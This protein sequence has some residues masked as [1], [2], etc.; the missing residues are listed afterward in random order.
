[1]LRKTTEAKIVYTPQTKKMQVSE[2]RSARVR[3]PVRVRRLGVERR[4]SLLL[5]P[6][7]TL[8]LP[9]GHLAT[10]VIIRGCIRSTLS[11]EFFIDLD[12][13]AVLEQ[14]TPITVI[15]IIIWGGGGGGE[16]PHREGGGRKTLEAFFPGKIAAT[17]IATT[18]VWLGERRTN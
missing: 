8:I 17:I 3:A 13:N 6:A 9:F 11:V 2:I 12:L 18:T 14:T 15:I 4:G 1:M 7:Q 16:V 5:S 10:G